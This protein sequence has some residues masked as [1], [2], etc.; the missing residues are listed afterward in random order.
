[1][2]IKQLRQVRGLS[3]KALAEKAG[4]AQ[5]TVHYIEAGGNATQKTLKKLA[6]AL[7]VKVTDLLEEQAS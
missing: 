6:A 3:Q 2:K 5:A 4:V 7:G 1:M